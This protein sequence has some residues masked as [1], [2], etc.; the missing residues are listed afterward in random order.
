MSWWD[1]AVLALYAAIWYG[2]WY[3]I[4]VLG[5]ERGDE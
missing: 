1:W 2:L 4:W 3:I 5:K